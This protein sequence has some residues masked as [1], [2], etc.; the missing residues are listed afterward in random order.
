MTEIEFFDHLLDKTQ[1]VFFKSNTFK[2][3]GDK[4]WNF[5]ICDTPIKKK[6]GIFFGLNWGGNDIDAQSVYPLAEKDRNWNFFSHSRN[7]FLEFLNT[8]IEQLNYTNLRFFRSPKVKQIE[9]TD[10]DKAIPLFQE[11]VDYINPPWTLMLGKP[12][13]LWNDHISNHNTIKKK[14]N[15]TNRNMYGYTGILFGKYP[16]GAVPHPQAK[17]ST[18]TRKEIWQ[19]VI[20]DNAKYE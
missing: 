2:K 16:F 8:D 6:T 15:K 20:K 19:S 17:I 12:N 5:A 14:D 9:P 18:E 7:Y 13:H 10:W 11:Y 1:K 4:N 3:H